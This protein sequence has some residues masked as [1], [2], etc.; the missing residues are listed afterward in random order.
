LGDLAHALR[1]SQ[2]SGHARDQGISSV[3]L[4]P[5]GRTQ[6]SLGGAAVDHH[7]SAFAG[8]SLG[9]GESDAG[10]RSGNESLLT[11]ELQIHYAGS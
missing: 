2:V 3:L 10:S 5:H 1:S 9:N 7:L 11:F 6:R 4:D 8:E